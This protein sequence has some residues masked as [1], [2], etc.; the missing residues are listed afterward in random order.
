MGFFDRFRKNK[1]EPDRKPVTERTPVT[2]VS[3]EANSEMAAVPETGG[4][5]A[6]WDD[7]ESLSLSMSKGS[8]LEES[9]IPE[10]ASEPVGTEPDAITNEQ[11][12]K[13]TVVLDTY[14]VKSDAIKGG[15]GSVWKVHHNGWN[16]DLAMKRPQPKFFAEGSE[17]RKENFVHECEAW[18]NL[19]LHPNI[20]SCYY[21]REI[22]GVPTIFSEWMENGSL[23]NRIDDG[24]LYEGTEEEVQ[25]R[26][27]DIAIQFARGLHYAHESEGHLIHQDVKP[28][29]LLLTKEWE[30]KVADFGLARAR[31]QMLGTAADDPEAGSGSKAETDVSDG[32]THMAPTGGYTPAYCSCEQ[33]LGKPLTRRTDIYSWA[34]SVMEMYLGKRLWRRGAEAGRNCGGYFTRCRVS[35]PESLQ[36]VLTQ[37]MAEDPDSRPHD[38]AEVEDA[39]KAIY[40]EIS[41]NAYPRESPKAAADTPDSLNNQALSYL[42]LGKTVE[43]E[44]LWNKALEKMPGHLHSIY[45][46]GLFLWRNAQIDDE[47]LIRRCVSSDQAKGDTGLAARWL[48]QINGERGISEKKLFENS[49]NCDMIEGFRYNTSVVLTRDGKRLYTVSDKLRCFDTETLACLYEVPA[50]YLSAKAILLTKDEKTILLGGHEKKLKCFDAASGRLIYE[51]GGH[52]EGITRMCLHPNGK[53]CYTASERKDR[54]IRKWEIRT[55][56]CVNVY[57]IERPDYLWTQF[58]DMGISP[59][60]RFLYAAENYKM[61]VFDETKGR[62]ADTQAKDFR[63]NHAKAISLTGDGA[64]MYAVGTSSTEIVNT[65]TMTVAKE[66]KAFGYHSYLGADGKKLLVGDNSLK[67]WDTGTLR[68]ERTEFGHNKTITSISASD[69]MSLIATGFVDGETVLLWHNPAPEDIRPAPWE[70]SVA[71]SYKEAAARQEKADVYSEQIQT[72]IAEKNIEQALEI[73]T[74]AEQEVRTEGAARLRDLRRELTALCKR[75]ALADVSAAEEVASAREGFSVKSIDVNPETGQIALTDLHPH[76]LIWD[77]RLEHCTELAAPEQAF[78]ARF[79]SSGRRLAAGLDGQIMIWEKEEGDTY[80]EMRLIRN[81]DK[82][83][84]FAIYHIGFSPDE[85]VVFSGNDRGSSA[86]WEAETGRCICRFE[87]DSEDDAAEVTDFCFSPDGQYI[88]ILDVYHHLRVHDYKNKKTVC[89]LPDDDDSPMTL[90]DGLSFS[91]DGGKLF[92]IENENLLRFWD[93]ETW[94]PAGKIRLLEKEKAGRKMKLSPDGSYIVTGKDKVRIWKFPEA[95]MLFELEIPERSKLGR[96]SGLAFSG[97]MTRLYAINY[98]YIL[99]WDLKW[100]LE[101]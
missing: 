89:L 94:E 37:C 61:D 47:E 9:V 56:R 48:E 5:E 96:V 90:Y 67:I 57:H 58:H 66:M 75:T 22:S 51:M 81:V 8:V 2:E 92:L 4:S 88:A 65:G 50:D 93:T 84:C 7:S 41:G 80:R 33:I 30:A 21:V 49:T 100:E 74:A 44:E 19:G 16:T 99:S 27:L 31:T 54:T 69:D 12:T 87:P 72:C 25:E 20:V 63:V 98:N 35:M 38:F 1:K 10:D 45:N 3:P 55:G 53:F 91:L 13:D 60:G 71:K 83:E 101:Q 46:Y 11:I 15:M 39:L 78:S 64:V 14:L 43:A 17:K 36:K 24:C 62:L 52:T 26:L 29:N 86:L 40:A 82:D 59:D 6:S 23:K 85:R 70:L 34:V 76:V 73:L 97:D 95:E 77:D 28:D 68:C 42:D 79:S 32:A 18:I